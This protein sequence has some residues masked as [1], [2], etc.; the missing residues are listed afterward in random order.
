VKPTSLWPLIA[1]MG[2]LT[3]A[4]RAS[5][6]LL[7][8]RMALPP[9]ALRALGF[10]PAAVLSALA[11]PELLGADGAA[12]FAAGPRLVAGVL[13]VLVAWRTRSVFLTIGVGMD[14]LW[15]LRALR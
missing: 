8:G 10:V 5:M 1:G 14:V 3:L 9:L 15:I 12:G 2:A 13:A 7:V 11:V 6:I 4:L